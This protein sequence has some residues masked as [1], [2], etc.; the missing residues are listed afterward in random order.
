M[1][2]DTGQED[3]DQELVDLLDV[4][5]IKDEEEPEPSEQIESSEVPDPPLQERMEIERPQT[6][7]PEVVDAPEVDDD[8]SIPLRDLT[9]KFGERVDIVFENSVRDRT[10]IQEVIDYCKQK[11]NGEGKIPQVVMES[12]VKA[13]TAK[14]DIN[15]NSTK[16]LDSIARF[17]AAAKNN[18]I[19]VLENIDSQED[20]E[21]LLS[22]DKRFDEE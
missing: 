7:N 14:A 9:R 20:L 12:W 13:A 1:P 17:L 18:N 2:E 16:L 4:I 22:Q 21:A 11:V 15:I 6:V 5:S 8:P 19:F 10:D 3:V